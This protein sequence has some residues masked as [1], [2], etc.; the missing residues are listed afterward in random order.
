MPE[1]FVWFF[2]LEEMFTLPTPHVEQT[3][4][5]SLRETKQMTAGSQ[6]ILRTIPATLFN[7]NKS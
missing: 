2:C 3:M 6:G 1:R 7:E 4:G 5:K